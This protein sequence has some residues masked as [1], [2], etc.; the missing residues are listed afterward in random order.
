MLII[1]DVFRML[2]VFIDTQNAQCYI[3]H[4]FVK[5]RYKHNFEIYAVGG[6]TNSK[7]TEA[8]VSC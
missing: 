2:I 7:K 5:Q 6:I 8:L 4:D 3:V 1:V